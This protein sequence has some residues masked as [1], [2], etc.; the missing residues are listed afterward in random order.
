MRLAGHVCEAASDMRER[1]GAWHDLL[2]LAAGHPH[3]AILLLIAFNWRAVR[4]ATRPLQ[5]AN[6]ADLYA[7]RRRR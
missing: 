7:V 5:V 6:W 2:G 1:G 4:L 3:G